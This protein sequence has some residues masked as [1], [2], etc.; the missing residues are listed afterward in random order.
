M[1]EDDA[2]FADD[3]AYGGVGVAF[4]GAFP[5]D[6]GGAALG[7]EEDAGFELIPYNVHSFAVG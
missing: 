6:E 2:G 7:G 5:F 1:S 4:L 3:P